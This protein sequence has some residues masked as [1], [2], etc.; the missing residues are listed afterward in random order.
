MKPLM[1]ALLIIALA[2]VALLAYAS[3]KPDIFRVSRSITINSPASAVY[4]QVSDVHKTQAWSPWVK[5]EPDAEYVF[6]GP[7]AGLGAIVKWKGKKVGQGKSTIVEA[8]PN[9]LV[10]NRLDFYK[11]MNSTSTADFE[12][13][14]DSG[15]TTV[16]WSMY[17]PNNLISKVMSVFMN[18]ENMIGKQFDQGLNDLK[19]TVEKR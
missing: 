15:K 8:V 9:Q 13:K 10:R 2:I 17:G 6:E 7:S 12:L 16:V 11:P 14:E 19:K 3:T 4:E 18:C 1:T 5:M